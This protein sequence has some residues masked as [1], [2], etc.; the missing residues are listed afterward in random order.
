MGKKSAVYILGAVLLA[1]LF[2]IGRHNYLLFHSISEL[3]SIIV[4][5]CI[6][7]VAWNCR[8]NID[9]NYLLFVGIAYFFVGSTD[10]LHALA[11]KG[12][13]VFSHAA[14]SNLATQ[15]WITARY[16][17]SFS[18][19]IAPVF[20]RRD[21]RIPYVFAANGLFLVLILLSIFYWHVFPDTYIESSGLT[22]FKKISELIVS[23]FFLG[24]VLQLYRKRR[25][26]DTQVY[27]R[28]TASFIISI[29]S[30][31]AF[32]FY[33][34]VYGI[35]NFL[36]HI[37][38]IAS[39]YLI[40]RAII[41]TGLIRPFDILYRDLK[42][43]EQTLRENESRLKHLNETKDKFFSIIAHD[44]R[45]PL[46]STMS[47][48][49]Y[50]RDDGDSMSDEERMKLIGE[51]QTSTERT[52]TL[53]DNLLDWEKCQSGDMIC[54]PEKYRFKDL[55]AD[56]S[57]TME[58]Y[59]H[60]KSI[61]IVVHVQ[62]DIWIRAD[63]NMIRTVIRNMISNAIKFS[64]P[65]TDILIEIE[66]K[67]TMAEFRISDRGIGIEPENIE[68]LFLIEEH[69][70][71]P[72]TQREKGTGLGLVLCESFIRMNGGDIRLKSR[73]DKGTTFIFTVP[74]A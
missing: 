12:M 70:T 50:L 62:G 13:G 10:L 33:T 73:V 71:R 48:F 14:E 24:S 37:L 57:V 44:L 1:G 2:L 59:A 56:A 25:R 67:N 19:F 51:V 47:V 6:F 17:E 40:Y 64:H 18:L 35:S 74:L 43:S 32:I 69:F 27:R 22:R 68:K 4:A 15:L 53:L 23:C 61:E 42:S 11:Y 39:F 34:D 38:K 16:L 66:K 46:V 7:I 60:N 28:L 36:G 26:F 5:F 65:H 29:F 49:S 52:I 54:R 31:I 21:I 72:G 20:V 45:T 9:N 8:Q 63:G 3:F 30:E 55:L 58:R 41:T